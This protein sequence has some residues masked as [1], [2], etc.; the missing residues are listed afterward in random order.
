VTSRL[1][2][3]NAGRAVTVPWGSEKRSAIDKRPVV[4]PVRVLRLGLDG[5]EQADA[6]HHGG[7][8]QAVYAVA[9]EDLDRWGEHLGR[10][11]DPGTFGENLTTSG[12]DVTGAVIGE[13]W[14][15]G[16]VLL[17]VSCPRIPCSV[18]AGWM[19]ERRWVKRFTAEG[20][21]GAYLRVTE[22]GTLAAGD[23]VEVV[24]RP[25]HGLTIGETFRALTGDRA[26]VPRLLDA[27]ELPEESHAYARTVLASDS[28]GTEPGARGTGTA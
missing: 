24:H 17:E 18:F 9:R 20:R 3:V 26:L 15:V 27:P 12:V 22:E 19:D 21:P 28:S 11:L 14:R 6:K 2:S 10:A 5:D 25:A 7:V 13:R 23:V 1:V 4:G 8:D 16:S